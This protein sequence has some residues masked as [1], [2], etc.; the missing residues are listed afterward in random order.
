MEIIIVAVFFTLIVCTPITLISFFSRKRKGKDTSNQIKYLKR[1]GIAYIILIVIAFSVSIP[2]DKNDGLSDEKVLEESEEEYKESC[3]EYDYKTVLR[4]PDD[5]VGKRVKIT[6][7][8]NS[9]HEENLLNNTKYYMAYSEGEYGWYGNMYGVF[10][11]RDED[12][13]KI[14]SDDVITVYGE[15]ASTEYTSSLIVS[16]QEIFCIEMKYMELVSE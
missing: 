5:Y 11:L 6:V 7:K 9:V 12:D 4:N 8:I 3:E 16:S 2:N 10:D 1:Q 14:L 13:F 15:I